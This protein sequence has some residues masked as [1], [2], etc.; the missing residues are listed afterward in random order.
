MTLNPTT[1]QLFISYCHKDKQWLDHLLTMLTPFAEK[2]GLSFWSD[3]DVVPGEALL[4]KINEALR[5]ANVALL[6]I[7]S[8]YLASSFVQ[9]HELPAILNKYKLGGIRILWIAVRPSMYKETPISNIQALNNPS[10][11][12]SQYSYREVETKLFNVCTR[13]KAALVEE[14]EG[15]PR[16]TFVSSSSS[17]VHHA[18]DTFK[19]ARN[20]FTDRME[21]LHGKVNSLSKIPNITN[22]ALVVTTIII[23]RER[24]E[25]E[26]SL[27]VMTVRAI[28]VIC[29]S[30]QTPE[31][32]GLPSHKEALSTLLASSKKYAQMVQVVGSMNKV[33]ME[34]ISQP[35]ERFLSDSP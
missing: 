34:A 3:Q 25:A 4:D 23:F 14:E 13:I 17:Q 6:L 35:V 30:K 9:Q 29:E 22:E 15:L 27:G 8:D 18:L 28:E 1:S 33:F 31:S 24:A 16:L 7:S 19:K 21:E 11:P 5:A 32:Y 10:T 26:L 20:L 2:H 12:L